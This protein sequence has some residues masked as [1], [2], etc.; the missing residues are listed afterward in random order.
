[1]KGRED[2]RLWKEGRR[3]DVLREEWRRKS[4]G[5]TKEKCVERK[6]GG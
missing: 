2:W 5:G 6:D 4:E 1:M 3:E